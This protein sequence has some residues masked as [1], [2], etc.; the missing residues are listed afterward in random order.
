MHVR[1]SR[2]V[3]IGAVGA[4]VVAGACLLGGTSRADAP[5]GISS[6]A[7]PSVTLAQIQATLDLVADK[8]EARATSDDE[9]FTSVSIDPRTNSLTIARKIGGQ[10]NSNLANLY[11]AILPAG[12]TLHY[13]NSVVSRKERQELDAK[14]AASLDSFVAHGTNVNTA[15]LLLGDTGLYEIYYTGAAPDLSVFGS[16][17]TKVDAVA[18]EPVYHQVATRY[19]DTNPFRG[20]SFMQGPTADSA[21]PGGAKCTS[22]FSGHSTTNGYYYLTVPW[23]CYDPRDLRMWTGTNPN[24]V[25]SVDATS[26]ANDVVFINASRSSHSTTAYIYEGATSDATHAKQV[27]SYAQWHVGDSV[28]LSGAYTGIACS[29]TVGSTASYTANNP[30]SHANQLVSGFGFTSNGGGVVSAGDSGGPVFR[31]TN[32]NSQAIAEGFISAAGGNVAPC[33]PP[34]QNPPCYNAGLATSAYTIATTYSL[35]FGGF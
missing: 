11:S 12:V 3:R 13:A 26:P 35:Q 22:G 18:H 8:I 9:A 16:L 19:A 27:T 24:F 15:G 31:L 7:V 5:V 6:N 29:V 17:S 21:Y 34:N 30:Y 4:V 1:K 2:R 20:G 10:A 23:H 33:P 14:L 25:G 32:N 28:C